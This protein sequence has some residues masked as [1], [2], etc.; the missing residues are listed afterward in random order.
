MKATKNGTL[1]SHGK[2]H[3]ADERRRR[4]DR[5]LAERLAPVAGVDLKSILGL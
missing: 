3:S 4:G 5:V 1:T 2:D